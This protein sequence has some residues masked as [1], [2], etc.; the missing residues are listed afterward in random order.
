ML[1]EGVE[2]P[3]VM[4]ALEVS[5]ATSPHFWRFRRGP[6]GDLHHVEARPLVFNAWAFATGREALAPVA[7][8]LPTLRARAEKIA[9][10]ALRTLDRRS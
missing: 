8:K 9:E 1:G 6:A 3:E 10:R 2:L 4:K 5:E 7:G